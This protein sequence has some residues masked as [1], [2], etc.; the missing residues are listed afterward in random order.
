MVTLE[1][2]EKNK[3]Y[4]LDHFEE[5]VLD[6]HSNFANSSPDIEGNE[7]FLCFGKDSFTPEGYE[8]LKKK[9][10]K[11]ILK[12]I[13]DWEI[14]FGERYDN[15][16]DEGSIEYIRHKS[17]KK[18]ISKHAFDYKTYYKIIGKLGY[19]KNSWVNYEETI[20]IWE[21]REKW[22]RENVN[23]TDNSSNQQFRPSTPQQE[24]REKK[25]NSTNNPSNQ[26]PE[27]QNNPLPNQDK[28]PIPSDQSNN[29]LTDP[30]DIQSYYNSDKA[31]SEITTNSQLTTPEQ[32]EQTQELLKVII[33]AELLIKEKKFNQENLTKLIKEKKQN[34][35]SYQLLNKDGKVDKVINELRSIE[36]SHK[37]NN[38][39]KINSNSQ[40]PISLT[41]KILIGGGTSLIF[42]VFLILIIKRRKIGRRKQV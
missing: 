17:S 16:V 9:L 37:D 13:K 20:R 38:S 1:Q 35:P 6:S 34:T 33:A 25:Q 8:E 10:F 22:F 14:V 5:Y 11:S 30:S 12:E 15:S 3:Q 32:K 19:R 24:G 29:L 23:V 41:T 4:V 40:Q 26:E 7:W 27:N 39:E 28:S 21:E 18:R 2:K 31:K 36:K 42:S